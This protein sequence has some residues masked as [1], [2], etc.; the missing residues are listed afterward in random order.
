MKIVQSFIRLSILLL[1]GT[2]F[3]SVSRAQ[4]QEVEPAKT[5]WVTV[6]ELKWLSNTKASL[7]YFTNKNDTTYLLYLQDDE[8]L[9]NSRDMT[10]RKYFSLQF[11]GI[12]NTIE[13]LYDQLTSFFNGE[14]SKDKKVEKIFRLGSEMIHVQHYPKLIGAAIMFSTKENHIVFT[15]KELRKL[16]GR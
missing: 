16:F 12:D 3:S 10:V 6:G 9:K 7:R 8:K 13:K 14:N 5:N 1:A 2:L 15:E 11:S 4:F